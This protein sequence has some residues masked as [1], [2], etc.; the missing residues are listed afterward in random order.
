M[1]RERWLDVV[2]WL[3]AQPFPSE[4]KRELLT[5]YAVTVGVKISTGF[6]RAVENSGVD[7]NN[8]GTGTF[9]RPQ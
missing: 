9:V 2:R 6:K 1:R 7:A 4:L 8:D 5:G 3:Q